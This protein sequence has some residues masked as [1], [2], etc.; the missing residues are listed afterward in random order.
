MREV[1]KASD[2]E[3][4]NV[5]QNKGTEASRWSWVRKALILAMRKEDRNG[6]RSRV[7]VVGV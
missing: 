3:R 7:G 4:A 1:E 6:P 2:S 5:L